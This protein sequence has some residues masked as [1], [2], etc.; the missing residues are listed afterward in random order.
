V[1]AD[2]AVA[3]GE[4]LAI[5]TIGRTDVFLARMAVRGVLAISSSKISAF[6]ESTFRVLPR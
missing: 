3:G 1:R 6:E 2:D 4:P 5:L